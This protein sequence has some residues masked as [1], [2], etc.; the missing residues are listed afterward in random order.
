LTAM[1]SPSLPHQPRVQT[2]SCL[3]RRLRCWALW[4]A[5]VSV[6]ACT[7]SPPAFSAS[8]LPYCED[9]EVALVDDAGVSPFDPAELLRRAHGSYRKPFVW[10]KVKT[11]HHAAEGKAATLE[12][13]LQTNGPVRRIRSQAVYPPVDGPRPLAGLLCAEERLEVPVTG[14]VRTSDGLLDESF[15]TNLLYFHD[16]FTQRPE[17]SLSIP[18]RLDAFRGSFRIDTRVP[19]KRQGDEVF[20]NFWLDPDAQLRGIMGGTFAHGDEATLERFFCMPENQC[21]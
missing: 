2:S 21:Y 8:S 14:R 18:M 9:T 19:A 17:V 4:I 12:L 15:A 10:K 1:Y 5:C 7:K 20:F 6:A 16:V 13:S 11:V 3:A